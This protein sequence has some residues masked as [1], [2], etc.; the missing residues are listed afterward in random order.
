MKKQREE[1]SERTREAMK[2]SERR[3]NEEKEQAGARKG[4]KVTT[5]RIFPNDS[6]LR[7]V[8]KVGSQQARSKAMWLAKR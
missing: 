7:R 8:E 4:R 5:H 3:K 1:E 6:W 2:R